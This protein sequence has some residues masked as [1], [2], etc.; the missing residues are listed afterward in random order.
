MF[1][2]PPAFFA[3]LTRKGTPTSMRY[4]VPPMPFTL[5]PDEL[6]DLVNT[7]PGVRTVRDLPMPP[8]RGRILNAL[9]QAQHL[10]I[11]DRVRPVMGL[12]E[13]G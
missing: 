11:F 9:L 7:V 2:L 3:F 1:D 12:L 4:R 10:P 6:A 8:G 13:F 5:S